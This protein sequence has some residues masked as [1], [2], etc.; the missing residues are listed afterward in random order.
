M[1]HLALAALL[2]LVGS[3]IWKPVHPP[4]KPHGPQKTASGIPFSPGHWKGT[5]SIWG[6]IA[7]IPGTKGSSEQVSVVGHGTFAF[8]LV[9]GPDG[10]VG[11]TLTTQG[12]EVVHGEHLSGVF[13]Y[14]SDGPL[15]LFGAASAPTGGG[16][17]PVN[18]IMHMQVQGG[19]PGLPITMTWPTYFTLTVDHANCGRVDGNLETT[20]KPYQQAAGFA[21]NITGAFVAFRVG[22]K[23]GTADAAQA[24]DQIV[25]VLQHFDEEADA[26]F[27]DISVAELKAL[28]QQGDETAA[29]IAGFDA[30]ADAAVDGGSYQAFLVQLAFAKKVYAVRSKA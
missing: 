29:A 20:A 15:H 30:C 3:P 27:A 12:D 7:Q 8:D 19:P 5:G 23:P 6:G 11:G 21:S 16:E 13:N 28:I 9:V 18:G 4:A 22:A 10:V 2:G 25:G 14:K 1:I 26:Q 17:L 24:A